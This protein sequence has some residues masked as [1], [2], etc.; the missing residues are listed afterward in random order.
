MKFVAILKDSLREAFDAKVFYFLAGLSCV[1]ILL[2]GSMSFQPVT[3]EGEVRLRAEQMTW[4]FQQGARLM[5]EQGNKN[6]P[7]DGVPKEDLSKH[8]PKVGISDF[9]QLT[10][11]E[12]W[13]SS[14]RFNFD[15]TFPDAAVA[16]GVKLFVPVDPY[17]LREELKKMI[18]FLD[19]IEV[20]KRQSDDP[21]VVSFVVTIRGTKVR[22]VAAWPHVPSLL[23]G[24]LPMR[25]WTNP[26]P[27]QVEFIMEILVNTV[28]AGI[29]ML[30]STIITAFFIPN[31]LRKGTVDMLVVKPMHRTTLLLYKFIGGLLF[32]F[33]N[34]A[35]IVTGIWLM[36]GLRSGFWVNGFLLSLG[37]LTFEFAIFYSFSTLFGV[38]TRSPIVAILMSCLLWMILFIVGSTYKY[39][40]LT[41]KVD[42]P[43]QRLPEWVGTTV[44]SVHFVL[45]RVQDL[46]VLN[47]KMIRSSLPHVDHSEPR[48]VDN[49]LESFQW[50]ENLI[51]SGIFIAVML[52]LSCWRFAT[53]D[54]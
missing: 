53:R 16:E 6:R 33:L 31:M 10:A 21:H 51:V 14:Y 4:L 47:S 40:E 41:R 42:I 29:A 26:V 38:L 9:Q 3:V 12:P 34:T 46:D 5:Q 25:F 32:M 49:F 8:V 11:G 52:S 17:G 27:S 24:L 44:E 35:L 2:T 37:V 20:K 22:D 28:G 36:M 39:L 43:S 54:Y 1:I 50:G 30:V 45:P 23:F 48:G 7:P 15:V 13:N 18:S 19:E